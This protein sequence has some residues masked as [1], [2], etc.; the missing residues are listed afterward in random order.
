MLAGKR[1]N[2]LPQLWFNKLFNHQNKWG[3]F[4]HC[5]VRLTHTKIFWRLYHF[6]WNHASS[7]R[8][9]H[10]DS[11]YLVFPV[12]SNSEDC[13]NYIL[14]ISL[15]CRMCKSD[16]LPVVSVHWQFI[17]CSSNLSLVAI[18]QLRRLSLTTTFSVDSFGQ[19][20]LPHFLST[21]LFLWFRF[22]CFCF[23]VAALSPSSDWHLCRWLSSSDDGV[24]L[25]ASVSAVALVVVLFTLCLHFSEFSSCCLH[26]SISPTSPHAFSLPHKC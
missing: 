10:S 21:C 26:A 25:I 12:F 8:I 5:P 23:S 9:S 1:I 4:S 2:I 7:L 14:S 17:L 13:L 19:S 20:R 18:V 15:S 16:H 22:Q 24:N 3:L 11:F 6:F